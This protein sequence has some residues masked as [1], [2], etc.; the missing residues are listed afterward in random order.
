MIT[1]NN[2][3]L[4]E[5]LVS[6]GWSQKPFDPYFQSAGFGPYDYSLFLSPKLVDSGFEIEFL[7]ALSN[8]PTDSWVTWGE[9]VEK[10]QP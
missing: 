8:V 3:P 5:H 2:D 1:K 7:T 4:V 6:E 10:A 9:D